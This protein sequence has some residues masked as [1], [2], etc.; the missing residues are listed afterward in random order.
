MLM[1]H[2]CLYFFEICFCFCRYGSSIVGIIA[3][4]W[5]SL[6]LWQ[7]EKSSND[8]KEGLLVILKKVLMLDPKVKS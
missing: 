6:D 7:N 1:Y 5:S 4:N 3:S 8:L 2:C